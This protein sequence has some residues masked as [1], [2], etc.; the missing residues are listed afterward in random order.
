MASSDGDIEIPHAEKNYAVYH[1]KLID[2]QQRV[3]EA[4]ALWANLEFAVLHLTASSLR[5][6][7]NDAAS[8]TTAFKSFALML[9]FTDRSM[10]MFLSG[11]REIVYWNSLCELIRELSGDRNYIAHQ[12]IVAHGELEPQAA[13]WAFVVP[14]VGPTYASHF[15]D[16]SNREPMDS[17]EVAEISNDIQHLIEVTME[18]NNDLGGPRPLPQK[19]SDK[20]SRRRPG[21]GER[22]SRKGKERS[23]RP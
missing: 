14:K 13:D 5:L 6:S 18:F 4:V 15:L 21:I 9:D 20:V 11:R 7:L 22:R 8:L 23:S 2:L 1:T 17:A 19:Y 10:K 3:G 12:G 16:K